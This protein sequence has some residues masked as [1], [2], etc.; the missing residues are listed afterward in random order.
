MVIEPWSRRSRSNVSVSRVRAALTAFP[1]ASG[2]LLSLGGRGSGRGAGPVRGP[3]ATPRA[4]LGP[5]HPGYR[6]QLPTFIGR[7]GDAGPRA[8]LGTE[9]PHTLTARNDLAY[10]TKQAADSPG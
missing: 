3:A 4:V 2:P 9:R 10:W 1:G 8:V 6:R 5:E 7:S